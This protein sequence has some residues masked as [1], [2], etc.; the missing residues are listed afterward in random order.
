VEGRSGQTKALLEG[1]MNETQNSRTI[2]TG[3]Q[4][5]AEWVKDG[6]SDFSEVHS[7]KSRMREF[8][9]S[10]SV[11]ALGSDPQGYPTAGE[12]GEVSIYQ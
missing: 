9:T 4:R 5:I 1:T 2:I 10:G 7:L 6:V 8:C 3:L 12:K 11:G